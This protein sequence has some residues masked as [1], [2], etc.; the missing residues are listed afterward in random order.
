[1]NAVAAQGST[2]CSVKT[3]SKEEVKYLDHRLVDFQTQGQR[4]QGR[5]Y[6][7]NR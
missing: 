7:N 1:M 5:T 4:N 3:K 6:F 2:S